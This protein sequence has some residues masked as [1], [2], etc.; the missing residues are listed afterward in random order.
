MFCSII[1]VVVVVGDFGVRVDGLQT[2][3]GY[4]GVAE[5]RGTGEIVDVVN[6]GLGS[7]AAVSASARALDGCGRV[8]VRECCRRC[9]LVVGMRRGIVVMMSLSASFFG[10]LD[11]MTVTV[12]FLPMTV[13][14][15]SM[16]VPV[17]SMIVE[18]QQ[19]HQIRG[20]SQASHNQHQ[21]RVGHDLGLHK[22]LDGI[23]KDCD[24]QRDQEDAID[25]RTQCFGALIAVGVGLGGGTASVGH[26][27]RPQA[28][29]EGEDIVEHVEG[30]R[31]ESERV[32]RVTRDE[33]EHEKARINHQEDDDPA[34]FGERHGV[35]V[36][37]GMLSRG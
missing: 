1:L 29:A 19:T 33:L 17:S 30:I 21:H 34:G 25:Q 4:D 12:V 35:G 15:S 26:L 28:D 23:E 18:Q 32:H 8:A 31:H 9:S 5:A 16:T 22:A 13:S 14:S 10:I 24:A 20:E 37:L 27:H 6:S 36:V 7:R 11:R 3:L 2:A